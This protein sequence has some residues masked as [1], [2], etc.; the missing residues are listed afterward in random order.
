MKR[1]YERYKGEDTKLLQA[2]AVLPWGHNLLLLDKQ[3]NS[4]QIAFYAREVADKGWSREMLL[5][6]IKGNYYENLVSTPSSNNFIQTLPSSVAEYANE[7]FRSRYNLGF[8]GVSEP[9]KE[10]DLERRLV[11]KVT[12][13][14]LELGKGFTFIGNQH[15]I[16]FN[17]KEYKVD[18]LFFHRGLHRMIAIDLKIG[19]FIPE[20]IGKMN[21]YLTLLDRIEKADDE[22]ASIGLILCAEKDHLEV[23][24]AL[25]DIGK[26]IG[27]A[28]YQYLLPKDDLMKVVSAEMKKV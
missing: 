18:M 15:V 6:A 26:P 11:E 17:G 28:E 20:Y 9:I 12:R 16:P 13:F 27:V 25:Q 4:K 2:V 14:I 5:N 24:V 8:L 10:L 23:E 1:F 21:Y 22:E 7:V 3:L 19:G